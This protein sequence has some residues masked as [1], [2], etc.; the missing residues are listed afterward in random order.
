MI[1]KNYRNGAEDVSK[2]AEQGYRMLGNE[3]IGIA[4]NLRQARALQDEFENRVLDEIDDADIRLRIQ[5]YGF[6]PFDFSLIDELTLEHKT[7]IISELYSLRSADEEHTTADYFGVA[8]VRFGIRQI[9]DDSSVRIAELVERL[10]IKEATLLFRMICEMLEISRDNHAVSSV[11]ESIDENLPISQKQKNQ[12]KSEVKKLARTC[13]TNVFTELL[14]KDCAP[15]V[16]EHEDE[17]DDVEFERLE[18]EDIYKVSSGRYIITD[19]KV[20]IVE[21]LSISDVDIVFSKC[22]IT[23]DSDF[24]VALSAANSCIQFE[25]CEFETSKVCREACL[26]GASTSFGFID[27][28]FYGCTSVLDDNNS[29]ERCIIKSNDSE[30]TV[31]KCRFE[32]CIG[33]I[34]NAVTLSI[35][36][37]FLMRHTGRFLISLRTVELHDSEITD[38]V[39]S[40][41]WNEQ[42][43]CVG[44]LG[45]LSLI[46]TSFRNVNIEISQLGQLKITKCNFENIFLDNVEE[47]GHHAFISGIG[48][49]PSAEISNTTFIKTTGLCGNVGGSDKFYD[50]SIK[51]SKFISCSGCLIRT[52]N[53][54]ISNCIF[55]DC[56]NN[57]TLDLHSSMLGRGFLKT[58]NNLITVEESKNADDSIVTSCKFDNCITNGSI[59]GCIAGDE[60]GKDR[61]F[62]TVENCEFLRC[63][64]VRGCI[65]GIRKV[66]KKYIEA[67]SFWDFKNTFDGSLHNIDEQIAEILD[68]GILNGISNSGEK[69]HINSIDNKIRKNAVRKICNGND[70]NIICIYDNSL[71]GNSNTGIVFTRD[72]FYASQFMD[73]PLYVS[74]RDIDTLDVDEK[75]NRKGNVKPY[76]STMTILTKNGAYINYSEIG[77]HKAKLVNVLQKIVG[78][79]GME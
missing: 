26:V 11:S 62:L 4:Q 69:I 36:N 14:A 57:E 63:N 75:F 59:I 20:R 10:N 1:N 17:R 76:D 46:N 6:A 56:L 40:G 43:F 58:S 24:P 16:D 21:M 28:I 34:F 7:I 27:C 2:I 29:D 52:H 51:N 33:A 73:K 39:S 38:C 53:A 5:E 37:C 49:K 67:I 22:T 47:G 18:I 23:F 8:V 64:P 71:T 72:G 15:I 79:F 25:Y 77:F 9:I 61:M 31:I 42:L 48:S 78:I 50:F 12:I 65:S 44:V 19:Q 32:N 41:D 13:G 45:G 35:K 3:I 54:N 30:I 74:Y 70:V 66:G 68:S 55:S 60:T